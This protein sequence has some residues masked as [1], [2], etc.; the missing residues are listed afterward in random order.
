MTR[1]KWSKALVRDVFNKT[2]YSPNGKTGRCWHCSKIIIR[3]KRTI[4]AGNGA[5]H[6]DHY[7]VQ[8]VDI[9]NQICCGVTDQ[10]KLSNLVPAC[11]K[12]NLSHKFERKRCYYC[13]RSQM[14]CSKKCIIITSIISIICLKVLLI[15]AYQI[16]SLQIVFKPLQG[17]LG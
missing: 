2:A 14:L 10:H 1:K 8:F 16:T 6:V 3:D 11:V 12:C 15:Q 17:L 7:P 5:W 4:K 13:G 9:E